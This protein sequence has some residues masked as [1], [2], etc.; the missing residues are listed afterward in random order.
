MQKPE[1]PIEKAVRVVGG[2]SELA[3]RCKTSQPRI[4]QCLNR[5]QRV[6]ADLVL[7]IESATEGEVTRHELRPDLYPSTETEQS[8]P[9]AKAKEGCR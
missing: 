2:Q 4:W 8:A 6:P 9:K 1:T 5:N 7:L 3:R